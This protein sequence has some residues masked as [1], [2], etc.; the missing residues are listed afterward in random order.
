M[1]DETQIE[2]DTLS[3]AFF[4]R[5]SNRREFTV[6]RLA[7]PIPTG[8]LKENDTYCVLFCQLKTDLKIGA[9]TNLNSP[10]RQ[11]LGW[12]PYSGQSWIYPSHPVAKTRRK[13]NTKSV[14]ISSRM[15]LQ[16]D[17]RKFKTFRQGY[18]NMFDWPGQTACHFHDPT[19][20]EVQPAPRM[21]GPSTWQTY[22][23]THTQDNVELQECV[24]ETRASMQ[25]NQD[26]AC[27]TL[28]SSARKVSFSFCVA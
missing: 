16:S 1:L 19:A 5:G 15:I 14:F 24:R 23:S 25:E 4:I 27:A 11:S 26:A 10:A 7:A 2:S 18:I 17:V 9:Y 21:T 20:H 12:S 6:P 28:S 8:H 3:A 13:E 22:P